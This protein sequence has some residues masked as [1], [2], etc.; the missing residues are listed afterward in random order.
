VEAREDTYLVDPQP[1]GISVKFRHGKAF[2]LKTYQGSPGTLELAGRAC[3]RLEGWDKW[4]FPCDAPGLGG[5]DRPG[6]RPVRKLIR[7]FPAASGHSAA[8]ARRRVGEPRCEV[9]LT[10]IQAGGQTWWTLG[11]ETTGPASQQRAQLEAAAALVFAQALP[12]GME[13]T[14]D[15]S[16]SY[17]QWLT[18]G[19]PPSPPAPDRLPRTGERPTG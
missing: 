6:W 5:A 7:K 12:G 1:S 14:A 16:Q 2:E 17:L 19:Q 11:F 4:S 15:H 9:E 3:G 10:E 18:G 8:G 13:L